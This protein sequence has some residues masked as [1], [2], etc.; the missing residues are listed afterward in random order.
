MEI[1]IV[2]YKKSYLPSKKR[3]KD[4]LQFFEQALM[5]KQILTPKLANKKLVIVFVSALEITKLNKK[6]LKK[7]R[8]TDILSFSP[9]EDDSLGELI[10]CMEKIT[11]Q[12]KEHQ[13]SLEEE[14]VYL[15]LHGLLHLLGYHHEKGGATAKKMYQI[16]DE[17]FNQWQESNSN[18]GF[19]KI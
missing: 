12:A 9:I 1:E 4:A 10:L 7:D 8:P 19:Q 18:S 17:I 5:Q 14:I 16:Q 6:F 11:G 15:L 13:L 2:N 3:I